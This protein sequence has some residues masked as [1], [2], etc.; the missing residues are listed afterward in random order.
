[1]A[2]GSGTRLWPVSR[3]QRSKVVANIIPKMTMLELTY[4][5]LVKRYKPEDI[6]IATSKNAFR[7]IHSHVPRIPRENFSLEPTRRE[8]APALAL[9]L[10]NIKKRKKDGIFVYVNADNYISNESAWLSVVDYARRMVIRQNDR[11]VLVGLPPLYPETGYGYIGKGRRVSHLK[12]T[13]LVKKFIEKPNAKKAVQ[14]IR[15]GRY[16]W[17]PTLIIAHVEHFLLLY[18]RYLPRI[19][20]LLTNIENLS[21]SRLS[22][23]AISRYFPKMPSITID[24]GLLEKLDSMYVIEAY[25]GWSDIGHWRS[26]FEMQAPHQTSVVSNVPLVATNTKRALVLL[27]SKKLAAL[28]NVKD[29]AIIETPEVLLISHL[30]EAGELKKLV[31]SLETHPRYKKYV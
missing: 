15:S 16:L 2:G 20:N 6:F 5:R 8:T 27:S 3:A 22:Q 23:K 30:D 25:F 31:R 12:N 14:F 13:F 18:K 17:N 26:V 11:V 4:K 19:Y 7:N 1:M 29:L 9:A 28:V 10:L 24:Y 21:L